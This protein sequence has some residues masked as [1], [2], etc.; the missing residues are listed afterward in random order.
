MGS[1]KRK[2]QNNGKGKEEGEGNPTHT[3]P[4]KQNTEQEIQAEKKN[5]NAHRKTFENQT[6]NEDMETTQ[7]NEETEEVAS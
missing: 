6:A 1:G 7:P 2:V 5:S 4:N 3:E